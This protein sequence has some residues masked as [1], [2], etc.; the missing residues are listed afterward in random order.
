MCSN[1][2][3]R[4]SRLW[5]TTLALCL[6]GVLPL[7]AQ[8]PQGAGDVA[9]LLSRAG[10][11]AAPLTSCRAEFRIGHPGEYAVA[12]PAA[13]GGR[14]VL[15]QDDGQ[16]QALTSFTGTPDLSCYSLRD[17]DRLND[18]IAKSSTM[19]GRVV[20]EWD[21]AVVCGFLEPTIAVCWQYAPE[22][23]TFVR[24]GGWTT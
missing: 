9:T 8:A 24:I 19:N 23:R 15:V 14:Y 13:E 21:G 16:T 7:R 3:P 11:T 10:V 22:S 4:P 20:A 5:F 12:L 6:V 18:T 1:G 17:A 2:L